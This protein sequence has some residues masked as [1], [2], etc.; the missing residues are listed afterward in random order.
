MHRLTNGNAAAHKTR[1]PF[2]VGE[3]AAANARWFPARMN[4]T[5]PFIASCLVLLFIPITMAQADQPPLSRVAFGSCAR[6]NEPQP[7]WEAIVAKQ[8]QLFLMIG[9]NIYGDTEDMEVLKAK[10]AQLGA[11][12]GF[13]KLKQTCPLLATWD[14]HDYGVNDGGAEYPCRVE[15]QQIF[16]DFFEVPAESPC[17][18]R[19]GVYSA[20]LFGAPE[21]R[22][23]VLL[24]D[25]R[26]FRSPLKQGFVPGERGSG[27]RG[28]YLPEDSPDATMLGDAQWKWL[29]EQLRQPA[30]VRIVASSVQ[31]LANEHGWERW[32][33]FPRERQRL[34]DTIRDS[35][36]EGVVFI[37]GD[38]HLA[39]MSRGEVGLG[40]PVWDITS[41]SL[42]TPSGNKTGAGT[43][44]ANEINSFR[45][46]LTYF[47]TNFGLIDIDWAVADPELKLQVCDESG[48]VVLMQAVKLSELKAK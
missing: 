25:T 19:P 41:S 1:P 26:Y 17:R 15:S 8:P 3:T 48:D 38:R 33:N 44:F 42:N 24:L 45:V 47:D 5:F 35:Q 37:S 28:K 9:D 7:I 23:Q 29:A 46:G 18:Q 34:F 10:Y 40:Y 30:R 21:Q 36:A 39:E 11:Q 20:H 2:P 14:D 12:P 13:Q 16:L 4:R 43:R 27:V 31:V 32:G 6:Q 22:V